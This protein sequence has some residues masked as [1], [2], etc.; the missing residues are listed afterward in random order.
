[1]KFA[2]ALPLTTDREYSQFWDSFV[3]MNKPAEFTYLRPQFSGPIDIVRNELVTMALDFKCTHMLMMD[4]DQVYP[5]NLIKVLLNTMNVC[6]CSVVAPIVYRRYPPF[7]PLIFFHDGKGYYKKSDR[8]IYSQEYISVAACGSG[9]VLYDMEVF[10]EIEM[11][12]FED[13]S[14]E[15][16]KEWPMG[17]PGE[18]IYF[19]NKLFR[20]G[21][22][23]W[24]NTSLEIIHLGLLGIDRNTS[25]L[26]NKI[27][28]LFKKRQG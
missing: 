17:G 20:L 6:E 13:K 4:T 1:M 18:D 27:G 7:D 8:E 9:C 3:V 25:K 12:W 15:K 19:C 5:Q 16:S 23:I 21:Y 22:E 14:K 24:V 28:E 11:P 26:Y 2:I 10:R